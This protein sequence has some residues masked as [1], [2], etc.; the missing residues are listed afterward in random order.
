MPRPPPRRARAP[1]KLNDNRVLPRHDWSSLLL[2]PV[3]PYPSVRPSLIVGLVW[4]IG[5]SIESDVVEVAGLEIW[6][7]REEFL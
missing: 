1:S 7:Q 6:H 5:G 2:P 3:E 4:L